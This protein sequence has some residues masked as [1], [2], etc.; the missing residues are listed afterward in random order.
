MV[1]YGSRGLMGISV[2]ATVEECLVGWKL[3]A[4]SDECGQR[5]ERLRSMLELPGP[6]WDPP[7]EGAS[8]FWHQR[9]PSCQYPSEASTQA[10]KCYN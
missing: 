8:S 9:L 3:G 7:E 10:S 1:D 6:K 2:G 4:G 5:D